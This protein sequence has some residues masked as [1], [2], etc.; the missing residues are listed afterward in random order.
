VKGDKNLWFLDTLEKTERIRKKILDNPETSYEQH[1]CNEIRDWSEAY[2]NKK[3]RVD[4][5][6]RM[7]LDKLAEIDQ[8]GEQS[9]NP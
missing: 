5:L 7:I 6:K 9:Q 8:M 1:M 2:P 3:R 4:K